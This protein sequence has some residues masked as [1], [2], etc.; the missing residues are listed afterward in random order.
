M[1]TLT[2]FP[3]RE[4][5]C[6]HGHFEI[7]WDP[8]ENDP[9]TDLATLPGLRTGAAAYNTDIAYFGWN[10]CKTFLAGPGSILRAHKDLKDADWINGEWISKS[11]Q[12]SGVRLYC[13]IVRACRPQ[14]G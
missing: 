7:A 2:V 12:I 6:T 10:R 8:A 1:V 3:S 5:L 4:S 13:D 11:D 14:Q 9:I